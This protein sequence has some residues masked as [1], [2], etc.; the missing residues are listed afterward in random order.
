MELIIRNEKPDD[1]TIIR[2]VN[3]A[4][5][6]TSAEAGL[7]DALRDN[8]A[9]SLS[10]VALLNESIVGHI[11]FSPVV[12][13]S[14]DSNLDAVGLGPMSI[15]PAYQG[16]GIGSRLV[17]A[18]L[19]TCTTLGHAAVVVLGHPEFYPRFGFVPSTQYGII[20]EYDVPPEVFMVKELVKNTLKGR[21]GTAKYHQ[22]FNE[23]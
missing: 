1:I 16:R 7:V 3:E 14:K 11:L 18:G 5:F 2:K 19:E 9:I 20:S 22:L 15:L 21:A 4:A 12:I 8:D 23:L 10:L 17:E 13:E 6:D